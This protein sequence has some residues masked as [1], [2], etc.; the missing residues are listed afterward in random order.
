MSTIII[1]GN[2]NIKT[3]KVDE[4]VKQPIYYWWACK[5]TPTTAFEESALSFL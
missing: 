4:N 3:R 2:I 5:M 1:R